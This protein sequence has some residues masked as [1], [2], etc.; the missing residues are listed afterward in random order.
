VLSNLPYARQI[1]FPHR[2][3]IVGLALTALAV[4]SV[5][6]LTTVK[7]ARPGSFSK[8]DLSLASYSGE[9]VTAGAVFGDRAKKKDSQGTQSGTQVESV[10]ITQH[11]LAPSEIRRPAG[12]FL[13]AIR[14]RTRPADFAF[15]IY[16]V[17][18]ESLITLN[19]QKGRQRNHKL[20]DLPPGEYVL[21]ETH[22][23]EWSCKILI[24]AK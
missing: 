11:G 24:S 14:T 2:P 16:R 23:P 7:Y 20:V 17:R 3:T 19:S 13:L 15:E 10:L 21:R 4:A 8:Q 6:G 12:P 18:G 5:F 22:H 9:R 1:R